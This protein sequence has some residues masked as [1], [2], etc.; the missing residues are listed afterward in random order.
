VRQQLGGGA[1]RELIQRVAEEDGIVTRI[2]IPKDPGQAGKVQTEDIIA[3]LRGYSVK[4]ETQS[5][6][7]ELRAEPL[8]SQVEIGKVSVLKRVWTKAWLDE[9]RFFPK[10]K[11]KDQVDATASAFNELSALT[12]RNRKAPQLMVVGERSENVHKVA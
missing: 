4:A 1:V 2:V 11:F 8:A 7:K 6:S 3:L 12:R 10:S 9:L 5:G